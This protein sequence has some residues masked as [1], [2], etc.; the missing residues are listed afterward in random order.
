MS[1]YT[2]RAAQRA[3]ED[4]TAVITVRRVTDA[5]AFPE[6]RPGLASA[7]TACRR[8]GH[9]VSVSTGRPVAAVTSVYFP[10][11]IPPDAARLLAETGTPL[12]RA[13]APYGVERR[14][15]PPQDGRTR[16]LLWLPVAMAWELAL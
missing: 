8:D 3:G 9:L 2:D 6:L 13:L 4:V 5:G 10:D 16:A 11:V 7:R 15:L 12:G 1:L 14:E